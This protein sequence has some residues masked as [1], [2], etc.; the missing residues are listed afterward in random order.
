MTHI[1]STRP[2]SNAREIRGVHLDAI[3]QQA[4][5]AHPEIK[6]PPPA[7]EASA[8][9]PEVESAVYVLGVAEQLARA[10]RHLLELQR[11]HRTETFSWRKAELAVQIRIQ[12]GE[13]S[14]LS[15]EILD[16]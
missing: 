10:T 4:L 8:M 14:R 16:V 9:P 15:D 11:Q 5:E 7:P 6:F 1:P 12:Q 2:P 3:I 13:V